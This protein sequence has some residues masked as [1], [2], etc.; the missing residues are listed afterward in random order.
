MVPLQADVIISSGRDRRK[1]GR[2]EHT[3]LLLDDFQNLLVVELR[4]NTLDRSQGFT[5]IALC[6]WSSQRMRP[7]NDSSGEKNHQRLM[8]RTLNANMDV[9]A[10]LFG[11]SGIFVGLG[12]GVC[13]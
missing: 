6:R 2:R 8:I 7:R 13:A 12:E 5:S 10:C 11:L 1:H 4:R 9:L 3:E